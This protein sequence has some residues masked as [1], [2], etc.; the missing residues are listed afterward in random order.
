[1]PVQLQCIQCEHYWGD[2][3]CAA[4]QKGIPLE[5]WRG[6][7]NHTKPYKGDNDIQFEPIEEE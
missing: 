3:K 2:G 7:N 4:F 1:M 6:D 5:I